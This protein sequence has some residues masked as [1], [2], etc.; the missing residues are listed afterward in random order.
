MVSVLFMTFNQYLLKFAYLTELIFT[1]KQYM[2]CVS[3][4][5]PQWLAELG[6]I[7]FSV[8]EQNFGDRQR[9]AA[10]R[11]F[12][13]KSEIESVSS[14]FVKVT[15]DHIL[16]HAHYIAVTMAQDKERAEKEKAERLQA[17]KSVSQTPRVVGIGAPTP[18]RTP[19]RLGM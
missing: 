4:V 16:I 5:D 7:F 8:R 6:G 9:K 11:E 1:S 19:R 18:K 10:D 17:L 14:H 3:S 13:R 2:S 12:N 15:C